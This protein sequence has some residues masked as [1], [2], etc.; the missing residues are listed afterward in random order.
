MQA[1]K[2]PLPSHCAI[3]DA[4]TST[5]IRWKKHKHLLQ[6]LQKQGIFSAA[7]SWRPTVHSFYTLH[8][9]HKLE[10]SVLITIII[11][12]KKLRNLLQHWSIVSQTVKRP[13][14]MALLSIF[15]RSCVIPI[16]IKTN[17]QKIKNK[18]LLRLE[19]RSLLEKETNKN[20]K[21]VQL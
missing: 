11:I 13:L 4:Y 21:L 20:G 15:V 5:Y 12:C 19:I 3:H 1:G 18:I 7:E 8:S 2:V 10:N 17:C 16:Q 6:A 9:L 14:E